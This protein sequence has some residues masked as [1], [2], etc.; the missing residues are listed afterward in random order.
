MVASDKSAPCIFKFAKEM[1]LDES[2]DSSDSKKSK[3]EKKDEKKATKRLLLQ[4]PRMYMHFTTEYRWILRAYLYQARALL[5]GDK[6]GLA[7]PYAIVNFVSRSKLTQVVKASVCP[8]F[9]ETIEFKD[10]IIY[11]EPEITREN[12]PLVVV[13]FYDK[14][15]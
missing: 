11:G 4:S 13:E 5:S 1:S 14:V 15:S 9:D 12:P 8:T 2:T 7:D 3:K 6:S 10:V